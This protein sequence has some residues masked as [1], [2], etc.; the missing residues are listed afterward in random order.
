MNN[1]LYAVT[2]WLPQGLTKKFSPW[3]V[4]EDRNLQEQH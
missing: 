2:P 3:M 4:S 1:V